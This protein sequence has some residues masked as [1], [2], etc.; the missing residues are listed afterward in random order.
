MV[1]FHS[2]PIQ[3]SRISYNSSTDGPAYC[4]SLAMRTTR[5]AEQV[6]QVLDA[7][8]LRSHSPPRKLRRRFALDQRQRLPAAF[9]LAICVLMLCASPGRSHIERNNEESSQAAAIGCY[10]TWTATNE[11][12]LVSPRASGTHTFAMLALNNNATASHHQHESTI[13]FGRHIYSQTQTTPT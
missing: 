3:Q 9:F 8:W 6:P 4:A 1:P 11:S 10:C 5:F 2:P 13:R 7:D 12:E